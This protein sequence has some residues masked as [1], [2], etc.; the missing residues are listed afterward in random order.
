MAGQSGSG[1]PDGTIGPVA[2]LLLGGKGARVG[3]DQATADEAVA[4][5]AFDVRPGPGRIAIT[6]V[7]DDAAQEAQTR[8][9]RRELRPPE[10]V[11]VV[12][13]DMPEHLAQAV[14]KRAVPRTLRKSACDEGQKR[15]PDFRLLG[16]V[17]ELR[18]SEALRLDRRPS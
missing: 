17:A 12:M 11:D 14:V 6:A 9:C 1:L 7:Q 5:V 18:R 2:R 16:R 13:G 15:V 10:A 3:L 4:D 8:L